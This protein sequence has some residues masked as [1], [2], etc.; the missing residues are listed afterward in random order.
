MTDIDPTV[1][2]ET[3]VT[4]TSCRPG[5]RDRVVLVEMFDGADLGQRAYEF[6]VADLAGTRDL[7]GTVWTRD[8]LLATDARI[9]V[10]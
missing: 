9:E 5:V 4:F 2:R 10:L 7:D 3:R 8:D 1:T 6:A